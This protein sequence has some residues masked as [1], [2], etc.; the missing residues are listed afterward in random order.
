MPGIPAPKHAPSMTPSP[1]PD[2]VRAAARPGAPASGSSRQGRVPAS[3]S[4]RKRELA[5]PAP[6]AHAPAASRKTRGRVG[7][8][9]PSLSQTRKSASQK[10]LYARKSANPKVT[11]GGPRRAG[12]PAAAPWCRPRARPPG[13]TGVVSNRHTS[14]V[15]PVNTSIFSDHHHTNVS[16]QKIHPHTALTVVTLTGVTSHGASDVL[17]F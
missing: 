17:S 10:R 7:A 2:F 6:Q 1:R 14:D 9:S 11:P 12:R 13:P 15:S 16:L 8:G 5:A 4:R 3:W